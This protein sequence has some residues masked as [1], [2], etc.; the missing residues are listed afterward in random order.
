MKHFF[1]SLADVV[2]KA[3]ELSTVNPN[4][5]II[6]G[7]HYRTGEYYTATNENEIGSADGI[8]DVYYDGKAL[9]IN[10]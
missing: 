4:T 9:N 2:N 3:A 1:N 10:S 8:I 7:Q 5:E 6:I